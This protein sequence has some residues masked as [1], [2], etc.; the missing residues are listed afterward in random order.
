MSACDNC[1]KNKNQ[2]TDYGSYLRTR[3]NN[4]DINKFI[5]DIGFGNFKFNNLKTIVDTDKMIPNSTGTLPAI[6]ILDENANM[7]TLKLP[8]S[9]GSD[10]TY[11]LQLTV[12]SDGK[13][14][15][16]WHSN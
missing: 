3:G 9:T 14:S 16:N 5:Y 7:K 11:T 12:S 15:F 13:N 10:K 1:A 8:A 4:V 6:I 2:Y